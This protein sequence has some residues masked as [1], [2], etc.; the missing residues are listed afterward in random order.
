MVK[1]Y[2]LFV[3]MKYIS[4]QEYDQVIV[5]V[6]QVD[7]VVIVVK[8]IVESVCINF[9]Y[10]KVIVLISGC[11]GKLIVIEGVFVING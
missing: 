9:V 8:V 7:V 2:V 1:C 3:G 10:I 11:I 6:C 5:D 4:Q